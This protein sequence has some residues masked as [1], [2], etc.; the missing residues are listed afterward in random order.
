MRSLVPPLAL[1]AL[2]LALAAVAPARAQAPGLPASF[3]QATTG[4]G[5]GSVWVGRIP[6][7]V[8]PGDRRDSAVYLPPGYDPSRRYPVLYLL[9]GMRGSPSSFYDG[10]RF[11][12]VADAAIASGATPPFIAVMPVAG[13]VVNPDSGE[14]AGVWERYVVRDVVPWT[15]AHLATEASAAGRALAGLCAGGFGAVDIGLRHPGLFR[16]LESWEGYFAPVFRDGPFAHA[17]P[18]VLAAHTPTLL[19]RSDAQALRRAGVRFYV[20]VG[21]N[22][23]AV[24]RSWSLAFAR[25]LGELRLPHRLWVLP[26]SERGHFWSATLPSALAYAGAGFAATAGA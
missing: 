3:T 12:D 24:L 9:H 11:A 22:H 13:P 21:G 25:E 7:T 8:V 2:A 17:A 6:N 23:G 5:G 16:T 1:V 20:S 18:A 19:V 26:R 10:L 4:A 14:W 15:D